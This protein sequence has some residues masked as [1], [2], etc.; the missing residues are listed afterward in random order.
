MIY[1]LRIYHMNKGKLPDIHDRFENVT[2]GLFKRYSIHVCDF[3]T[4][5]ADAERCYYILAFENEQD[6]E[7]KWAAFMS[8]PEWIQKKEKSH[9][10]G[11]I[12]SKI[13]SYLMNRVPYIKPEW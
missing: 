11:T 7:T 6:R 2:L 8:D 10:N 12:V 5:A 4:D 9:E 1:E 13:E 3:F